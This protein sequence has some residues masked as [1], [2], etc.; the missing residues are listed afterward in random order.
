MQI[1]TAKVVGP[2]YFFYLCGLYLYLPVA[3]IYVTFFTWAMLSP[4]SAPME[5]VGAFLV[6]IQVILLLPLLFLS[7]WLLAQ[8]PAPNWLAKTED[9]GKNLFWLLAS[10]C[11]FLL[12]TPLAIGVIIATSTRLRGGADEILG[13]VALLIW[14]VLVALWFRSAVVLIQRHKGCTTL[15]AFATALIGAT[16]TLMAAW[17]TIGLIVLIILLPISLLAA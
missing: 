6:G 17:F 7:N 15:I 9:E 1:G 2:R 14:M 5:R 3:V 12:G 13:V 8:T 11:F 16:V 4:D 10:N